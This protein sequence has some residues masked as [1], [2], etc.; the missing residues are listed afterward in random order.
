LIET[1]ALK[2]TIVLQLILLMDQ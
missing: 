2:Q 1:T